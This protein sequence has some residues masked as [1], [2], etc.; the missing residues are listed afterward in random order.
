MRYIC[1]AP[2][3]K[4]WFRMETEAEAIAES[5]L[6]HHAV[7]KYF[8]RETEKATATFKPSPGGAVFEQQI[9]L[10]AHLQQEMP[11]F[12]TLRDG[13]GNGLVTAMLPPQGQD[14][15]P[16]RPIVVGPENKDPYPEHGEAIAALGLH[17]NISLG[18]DRCFP[19]RRD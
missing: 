6:M 13:E 4:T 1:D 18:R 3:G 11:L 17:F 16:F 8:R 9:G 5:E 7:E 15:G 10:K 12:L 14:G 2:D 19:Y